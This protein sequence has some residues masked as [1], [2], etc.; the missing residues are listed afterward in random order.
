M[1]IGALLANT[2]AGLGCELVEWEKPGR[3]G[4]MRLYI[5]KP[6]GI[7]VEDCAAVSRQVSRVLEVENFA[8]DRLEV[9]SPGLDRVLRHE[10]DFARFA[11]EKA[12]VKLRL[13]LDGQRNFVGTIGAIEGGALQLALDGRTV[14][15]DLSNLESARL[16][17]SL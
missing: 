16:V 11:G 7:S 4:L 14:R 9:S 17:P 3:G 8:Y 6:G 5:D 1:E 10:R 2:V 12:R 13:P 15:V